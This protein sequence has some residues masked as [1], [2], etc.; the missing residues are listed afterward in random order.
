M[1]EDLDKLTG[2]MNKQVIETALNEELTEHPSPLTLK[3]TK[4][5]KRVFIA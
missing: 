4:F 2:F 5:R 3:Y 1:Q